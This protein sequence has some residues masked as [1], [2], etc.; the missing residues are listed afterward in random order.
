MIASVQS[1][2]ARVLLK[3]KLTCISAIVSG[4]QLPQLW[5]TKP[6]FKRTLQVKQHVSTRKVYPAV[7]VSRFVVNWLNVYNPVEQQWLDTI[8]VCKDRSVTVLQWEPDKEVPICCQRQSLDLVQWTLITSMVR[9]PE[10]WECNVPWLRDKKAS[11]HQ[12][13]VATQR[14]GL[15]KRAVLKG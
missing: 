11:G 3:C 15:E 13:S 12:L 8:N 6:C 10:L 9:I 5:A 2:R 14:N 4:H 1:F 7:T